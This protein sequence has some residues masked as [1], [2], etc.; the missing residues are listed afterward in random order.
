MSDVVVVIK[1]GTILEGDGGVSRHAQVLQCKPGLHP[2][3]DVV[4]CYAPASTYHPY[5]TWDY[6]H[7]T[8]GLSTGHYFDNLVE[9]AKDFESRR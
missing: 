3:Y 5:V 7:S 6:N 8:G 4:L 9:A 2:N 1:T